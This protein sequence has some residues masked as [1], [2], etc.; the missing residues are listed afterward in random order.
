[1]KFSNELE[2]RTAMDLIRSARK[3]I[4]DVGHDIFTDYT[5]EYSAWDEYELSHIEY[6]LDLIDKSVNHVCAAM[7]AED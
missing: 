3:M 1:M 7:F 2:L 5:D 6:S 4:S